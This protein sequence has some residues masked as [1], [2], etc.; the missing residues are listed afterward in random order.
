MCFLA[1]VGSSWRDADCL[2]QRSKKTE[3]HLRR[4]AWAAPLSNDKF[5]PPASS[6]SI[7][8]N[9]RGSKKPSRRR[10]KCS[11]GVMEVRGLSTGGSQAAALREEQAEPVTVPPTLGRGKGTW[12]QQHRECRAQG[13]QG[14][15]GS[16]R[17]MTCGGLWG[18]PSAT[19]IIPSSVFLSH[20]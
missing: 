3:S 7:C 19:A 18:S 8:K 4:A 20:F 9:T 16:S 11:A 5:Q 12:E 10:N 2:H 14:P 15:A 17:P 6:F 1:S 13:V